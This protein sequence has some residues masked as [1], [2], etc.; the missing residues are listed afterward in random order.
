MNW[1]D[2]VDWKPSYTALKFLGIFLVTGL[3]IGYI[4]GKR[5]ENKKTI[6]KTTSLILVIIIALAGY[7]W[8]TTP[9][10]SSG[11]TLNCDIPETPDQITKIVIIRETY[12]IQEPYRPNIFARKF[13]GFSYYTFSKGSDPRLYYY[14]LYNL[15]FYGVSINHFEFNMPFKERYRVEFLTEEQCN[16]KAGQLIEE[17]RDYFNSSLEYRV[18]KVEKIY[19]ENEPHEATLSNICY[20]RIYY[21]IYYHG[22]EL[23]GNG[24][25]AWVE[26]C[27]EEILGYRLHFPVLEEKGVE[28]VYLTPIDALNRLEGGSVVNEIKF[29]YY[30]DFVYSDYASVVEY[31]YLIKGN[32]D[33]ELMEQFVSAMAGNIYK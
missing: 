26:V 17:I 31:G 30:T 32:L 12:G 7:N 8:I 19:T 24:T 20:Y 5:N 9:H 25:D 3:G 16:K 27:D 15:A 11:I 28:E 21:D 33:G 14:G 2:F 13:A 23:L 22:V 10:L 18:E 4:Y 29:G 6:Y 1:L